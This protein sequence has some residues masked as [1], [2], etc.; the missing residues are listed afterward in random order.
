MPKYA[1][2]SFNLATSS[3]GRISGGSDAGSVEGRGSEVCLIVS[4][5]GFWGFIAFPGMHTRSEFSRT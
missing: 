4:E 2:D 5:L 1:R 3:G